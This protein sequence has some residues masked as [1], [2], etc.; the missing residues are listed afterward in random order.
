MNY[1]AG[2]ARQGGTGKFV[3]FRKDGEAMLALATLDDC[4]Q[5]MD[6]VRRFQFETGASAFDWRVRGGGW[7]RYDAEA[8]EVRLYGSSARYGPFDPSDLTGLADGDVFPAARTIVE[9]DA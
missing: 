1:A 4:D 5:H 3:V 7:W 9:R 8:G 6:I 2:D